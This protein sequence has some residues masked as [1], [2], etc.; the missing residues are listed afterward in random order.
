MTSWLAYKA[1]VALLSVLERAL[2]PEMLPGFATRTKV[3]LLLLLLLLLLSR[4]NGRKCPLDFTKDQDTV[5]NY[6]HPGDFFLGGIVPPRAGLLHR[7]KFDKFLFN[8]PVL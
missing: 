4:V 3:L 5:R 6:Y 2:F 7:E 1:V 8:Q